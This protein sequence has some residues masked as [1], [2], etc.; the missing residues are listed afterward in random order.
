MNE[1]QRATVQAIVNVFETGRVTGN[2]GAVTVIPGDSGH[3]SYG[4]SQ[5]SLGSGNLSLMLE[6]YCASSNTQFGA[7]LAPYLP[8]FAAKDTTLDTDQTVHNLLKAAAADPVMRAVQDSYFDTNYFTP[9]IRSAQ[10]IG[11]STILA[12]GLA[13]DGCIQGGW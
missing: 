2:Y 13:Y 11:L 8:R 1:L 10:S 3:L 12:Q 4:R 6:Q 9:A 5:A 7:A